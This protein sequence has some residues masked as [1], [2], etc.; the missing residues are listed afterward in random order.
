[1]NLN[2]YFCDRNKLIVL[3]IRK[4]KHVW[5]YYEYLCEIYHSNYAM[6]ENTEKKLYATIKMKLRSIITKKYQTICILKDI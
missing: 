4:K 5:R 2:F 6:A 1:M 3:P